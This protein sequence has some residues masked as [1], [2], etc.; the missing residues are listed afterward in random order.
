MIN[1]TEEKIKEYEDKMKEFKKLK[2]KYIREFSDS[3]AFEVGDLVEDHIGRA[4][5]KE[6]SGFSMYTIFGEDVP[7]PVY[8]CENITKKGFRNKKNPER[9]V[10]H[11]NI[12]RKIV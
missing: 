8:K 1:L 12:K 11:R 7:Y 6:I 3:I 2:R 5:I 9:I 4:R 10:F